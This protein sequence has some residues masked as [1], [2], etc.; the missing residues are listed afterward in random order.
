[1]FLNPNLSILQDYFYKMIQTVEQYIDE[2]KE[3]LSDLIQFLHHE[4]L[5]ACPEVRYSIKWAVPFYEQYKMMCYLN[6]IKKKR[7]G[8]EV[9]FLQANFFSPDIKSI[10]EFKGRKLVGG[11]YCKD[12]ESLPG[13][14]LQLAIQ[15]M[16]KIDR[17]L[18]T[19]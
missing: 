19:L 14:K 6:P 2:Q 10:L 18:Q 17:E 15:E 11:L 9:C 12:L 13:E 16:I 7:R 3:T 4:I 8:V 5:Y 1:M